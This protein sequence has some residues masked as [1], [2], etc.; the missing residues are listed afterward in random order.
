[1]ATF[2]VCHGS[3]SGGWS[4]E[5][6]RRPLAERGHVLWTPTYTGLGERSHLASPAVDLDTHI[7]DVLGVLDY[8]DLR[9]IILV[10][11]SYGGVVATGVADRAPERLKQLVYLDALIPED[12]ERVLDC[13][14]AE[15][16]EEMSRQVSTQGDGWRLPP[17]PLAP[18]VAAEDV[19]WL[20][21]RRAWQPFKTYVQRI[22]LTGQGADLPRT[23]VYCSE[24]RAYDPY[25]RFAERVRDRPGWRSFELASGHIPNVTKPTE[26]ADLLDRIATGAS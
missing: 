17:R 2:V 3:W 11:H 10:G 23:F 5:K 1:M 9:E 21:P 6:L 7:A 8:E 24:K 25:R 12:G 18:D 13:H 20:T 19:A 14:T 16:A 26:L 15:A 4:W 22:K